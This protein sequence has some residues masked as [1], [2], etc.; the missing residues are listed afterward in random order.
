MKKINSM[1]LAPFLIT[2]C[3]L[4]VILPFQSDNTLF[5]ISGSLFLLAT[6]L[7]PISELTVNNIHSINKKYRVHKILES[8]HSISIILAIILFIIWC[9]NLGY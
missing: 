9:L 6:I 7:I 5:Y 1:L 8:T 3:I 2:F 4:S